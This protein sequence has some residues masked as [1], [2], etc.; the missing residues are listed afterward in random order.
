MTQP[1][2]FQRL[3]AERPNSVMSDVLRNLNQVFNTRLADSGVPPYGLPCLTELDP[4]DRDDRQ[5]LISM[6]LEQI[7]RFEPRLT[8]VT[9]ESQQVQGGSLHLLMTACIVELD[10]SRAWEVAI[11]PQSIDVK[12]NQNDVRKN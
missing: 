3:L 11:Q 5:K 8:N 6:I 4:F 2:L 7:E 9:I 10:E 12:E 1:P